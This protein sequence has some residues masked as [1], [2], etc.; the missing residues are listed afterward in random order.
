MLHPELKTPCKD[1]FKSIPVIFKVSLK[2]LL[3]YA[4]DLYLLFIINES[5]VSFKIA[6]VHRY[7]SFVHSK[8]N[9]VHTVKTWFTAE[10]F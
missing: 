2:T 5:S 6:F 8:I 3:K 10:L 7:V 1:Y 9:F 4:Q